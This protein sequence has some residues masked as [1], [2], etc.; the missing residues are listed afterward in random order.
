MKIKITYQTEQEADRV[1]KLLQPMLTNAKVKKSQIHP[2]Y[3][4]IYIEVVDKCW[5]LE[6]NNNTPRI[7]GGDP[8][9]ITSSN[10][11]L[12]KE[13]SQVTFEQV[14]CITTTLS[15][16]NDIVDVISDSA[17][18]GIC[19]REVIGDALYFTTNLIGGVIGDCRRLIPMVLPDEN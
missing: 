15:F 14:D 12:E 17:S 19:S 3:K 4:H 6:Q 11:T 1:L 18:H 8:N 9:K 10:D 13:K 2:P 5:H 16:I 7:R